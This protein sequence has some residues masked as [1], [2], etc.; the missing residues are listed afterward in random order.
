[1]FA[2]K[3]GM[4]RGLIPTSIILG[5]TNPDYN[6]IIIKFGAYTQV[7]IGTTNITNY[8]IVENI[9]LQPANKRRGHYL[10]SLST[11]KQ[12]HAYI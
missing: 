8:R 6:K 1:M 4:S 9:S 2:S 11:I 10:I 5:S 7:Y 12:I 3:N